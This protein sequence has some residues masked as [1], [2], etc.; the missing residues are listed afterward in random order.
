VPYWF[1]EEF[2]DFSYEKMISPRA[3]HFILWGHNLNK[4]GKGSLGDATYQISKLWALRVQRRRFLRFSYE[5]GKSHGLG[6]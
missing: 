4:L 3:Q 5:T 6:P 2:K 1:R